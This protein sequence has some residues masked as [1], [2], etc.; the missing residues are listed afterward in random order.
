MEQG[1]GSAVQR[2]WGMEHGAWSM[3]REARRGLEGR[4]QRT[5]DSKSMG[6]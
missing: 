5:D 1:A 3:E 2:A 4:R 6:H